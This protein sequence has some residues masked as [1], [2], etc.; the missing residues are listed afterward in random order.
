[1][2]ALSAL[3]ACYVHCSSDK[4][5][6]VLSLL[7]KRASDPRWRVRE[8]V[9]MAF[10]HI[11]EAHFETAQLIFSEWLPRATQLE[12][13]AVLAALAHPAVLTD[14][15]R[16]TFCMQVT[17]TALAALPD[18]VRGEDVRVLVQALSYV[19]SVFCASS[20][21]I[22]F[23]YMR[24]WA[25]TGRPLVSRILLKNLG[26]ARLKQYA[27]EIRQIQNILRTH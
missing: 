3:G 25:E 8:A 26:K 14:E 18:R 2:A 16:V 20:P 21:R 27:C 1:M 24:K 23:N 5:L 12:M 6:Q 10:Q 7:K 9:A 13:R 11:L 17:E 19:I 4:Q 22:G 15:K